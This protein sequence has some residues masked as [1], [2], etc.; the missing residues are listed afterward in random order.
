VT[1]GE[2][3][4]FGYLGGNLAGDVQR[5]ALGDDAVDEPH[6][7]RFLGVNAAAGED[8]LLRKRRPHEARE[9]LGAAHAGEY[10]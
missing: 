5:L 2:G 6:L 10:P 7:M 8:Q 3:S 4:V 9:A 1:D